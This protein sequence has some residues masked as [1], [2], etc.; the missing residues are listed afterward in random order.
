MLR[1]GSPSQVKLGHAEQAS[2][3][4]RIVSR[5]RRQL[6]FPKNNAVCDVTREYCAAVH[7][8]SAEQRSPGSIWLQSRIGAHGVT[9]VLCYSSCPHTDLHRAA[10]GMGR[11]KAAVYQELLC[12]CL[13]RKKS[14]GIVDVHDRH[15]EYVLHEHCTIHT[16]GKSPRSL[17]T[18]FIWI[19][20]NSVPAILSAKT[21]RNPKQI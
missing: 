5:G 4:A 1:Q 3:Y 13:C 6:G 21:Q 7:P 14:A 8:Q 15:A 2:S 16:H 19:V 18:A 9:S 12:V 11:K 17:L 10:S 20:F